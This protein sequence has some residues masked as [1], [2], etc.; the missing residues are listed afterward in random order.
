MVFFDDCTYSDNCADVAS[1]CPGVLC[2][3]TPRGLT[4]EDFDLALAAFASGKKGVIK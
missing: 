4:E 1:R 2:V 3:R